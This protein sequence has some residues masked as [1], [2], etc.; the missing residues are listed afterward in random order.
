VVW[1]RKGKGM[2]SGSGRGADG[3]ILLHILPEIPICPDWAALELSLQDV[4]LEVPDIRF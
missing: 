4:K 2:R 1:V 3:G